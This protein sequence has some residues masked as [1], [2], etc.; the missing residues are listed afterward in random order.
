MMAKP[1][2]STHVEALIRAIKE[3][4]QG[5]YRKSPDITVLALK[6][7]EVIAAIE[8]RFSDQARVTNI[9]QL[10]YNFY[11]GLHNLVFEFSG[12][13]QP[14]G[15]PGTDGFLAI[16]DSKGQLIGMV[17]PF[18]PIQPNKF[19][20]PLPTESEQPFVLDRP[21]EEIA[22]SDAEMYPLQVR[23]REFMERL[24]VNGTHFGD[25]IILTRCPYT[26]RT[27]SDYWTD[28]QNDECGMPDDI[29]LT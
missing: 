13:V 1:K 18:D 22:F 21:S 26:T 25:V 8:K 28:Y 3:E 12:G 27:P 19:M 9:H 16:L 2:I 10:E 4:W 11:T 23:S 7:K 5:G 20:P 24:K 15:K 6:D 17:D 14:F 29:T